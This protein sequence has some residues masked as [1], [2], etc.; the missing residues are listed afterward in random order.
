MCGIFGYYS[1]NQNKVDKV[2]FKDSLKTI[3]HRG[4]NFQKSQ[5]YNN[6]FIALGHV[7]LSIIDLS[8]LA[9]QPMEV[10]KYHI[11][12]NGEIYNYIEL[13][14][15]LKQNG[16]EFNTNSDTEVLINAYDYWGEEC[17]N[18][19]NGMWSFAILNVEDNSLFCSRDRYGVKPFNY[20]VDKDRFIFGS[21]IK[22]IITYDRSLRKPNYNSIALFCR[23]GLGG[24]IAETWFENILRLQP[25]HNL[26]VRDG[27]ITIYKYY[28]YPERT[29]KITFN[30]AKRKFNNL[31]NDAVK[32]RMRSDVPVGTTLSGG[33]DSTSIVASLRTFFTGKHETFTAHFPSFGEDELPNA[34]KTNR[35]FNLNGNSVEIDYNKNYLKTLEKIIYH[36]E[37]GHLSPSI[38]PLWKIYA[39]AKK[40]VTVV[41]EGQ[42]AD[43]LMAGYIE[44]TA[45]D[46]IVNKLRQLKIRK[47]L[48]EFKMLR[49]NYKISKILIFYFRN[50][51][52]S[53]AKASVRRYI[54]K[55]EG[56]LIGKL[57][58]YK[59]KHSPKSKSDSNFKK[60]LQYSHQ[61][62]LVNLLHYGDAISMA[63][64]IESRLPFM[65]YRL[66]DFVM[67]LPD[68]YFIA[69]GKG[70]YILREA[71][72]NILPDHI[73]NDVRKLGFP[74][75]INEFLN[76]NKKFIEGILLSKKSLSRELFDEKK[77]RKLIA[78][79]LDSRFQT[80]RFLFRL[81]CV[82][83]WFRIF[84]DNKDITYSK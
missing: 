68:D 56:V 27:K 46:F 23:E 4:P 59:Y 33:L 79:N 53:F 40:K 41:L 30:E 55:N 71:L 5:F 67:T 31:F 69:E 37:S 25:A 51:L 45:G 82:E 11:V 44:L 22:T 32:L 10:K 13:R 77:I 38:F 39:N 84:I 73:N 1:F 15:H 42:G 81:I 72:K 3:I 20:Y 43:E 16:Y 28:N 75:P 2:K 61:T 14:E 65:D 58:Y 52:P 47:A 54:L 80:S 29:E 34:E 17:V 64:S 24:E 83:L 50:N 19:F 57:K 74:S 63:F 18:R 62:T 6:D 12:F 36:L 7:R 78:T 9:N 26:V 35:V 48:K 76:D 8:E 49:N 66:I 21:E 70:K 60:T